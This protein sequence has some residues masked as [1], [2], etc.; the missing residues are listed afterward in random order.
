MLKAPELRKGRGPLQ[1]LACRNNIPAARLGLIVPK[2]SVPQAHDR[3]RIKRVVRET[4]RVRA[5]R[6]ETL[7]LIVRVRGSVSEPGLQHDLKWLF[8]WIEEQ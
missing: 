7:D 4:F 2:R 3:N 6:F 8:D 1:V 5:D